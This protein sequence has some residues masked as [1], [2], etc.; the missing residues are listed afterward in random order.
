MMKE[1]DTSRRRTKE[2][3]A[4]LIC[5][6]SL[7]LFAPG[8]PAAGFPHGQ[9]Q[10]PAPIERRPPPQ[11]LPATS[12]TGGFQ[13]GSQPGSG[14]A[15]PIQRRP[16]LGRGPRGEH[17]PEWMNEHRNLTLGQQQDALGREPGFSSLPPETQQRYRDRLAQL[18]AMKPEQRERFVA[19]TEAMER[20]TP[21]QRA[22]VRGAMSQLGSLPLPQR[23]MVAHTFRALRDLPP[24]QRIPA[25]N[26]GRF[27]PPLDDTQRAVLYNLL[28]VEPMLLP[29]GR[30]G[31]PATPP[32][33]GMPPV[34][35]PPR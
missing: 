24:E 4:V 23:M 25:L 27:G 30:P 35:Q 1:R 15:A 29:P 5:A 14:Y 34:G 26:S 20:L 19:R 8:V 12:P 13:P 33:P 9:G 11:G 2:G 7:L 17:F 16:P 3:I 28:R 6:V 31:V 21:D 18:N 22:E 10:Q 32:T